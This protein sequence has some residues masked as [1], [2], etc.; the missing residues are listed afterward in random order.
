MPDALPTRLLCIDLQA[1]AIPDGEIDPRASVAARQL[2][3]LARRLDWTVAH[4]RRRTT[5]PVIRARSG[6]TTGLNPLMTEPVYFHDQ[7]SIADNHGLAALLHDW[8]AHPVL[9]AAFDPLALLSLVLACHEPGPKLLL[10]EDVTP[11]GELRAA[12][13]ANAFHGSGWK[14]AFGAITL[15][16][17]A[18][19]ATRDG[20]QLFPAPREL[21][22]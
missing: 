5:R 16:E 2:L 17:L 6:A 4:T 21:Q 15:A 18:R 22:A 1:D 3:Q 8:R 9:V 10:V 20:V 7:R 11:L 14:G 13:P 12:A 19:R